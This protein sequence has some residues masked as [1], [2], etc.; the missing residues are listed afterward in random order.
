MAMAKKVTYSH[1]NPSRFAVKAFPKNQK[2][3]GPDLQ[4]S[5]NFEA[6]GIYRHPTTGI[7]TH[8]ALLEKHFKKLK[9]I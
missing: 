5:E 7:Q 2:N 9:K 6:T 4:K 3:Q 1:P 8:R